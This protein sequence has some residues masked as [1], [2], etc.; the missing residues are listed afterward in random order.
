MRD[1]FIRLKQV[2][3]TH[4]YEIYSTKDRPTYTI[5]KS[6]CVKCGQKRVQGFSVHGLVDL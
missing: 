6:K 1:I 3:C 2:F 5:I 4:K